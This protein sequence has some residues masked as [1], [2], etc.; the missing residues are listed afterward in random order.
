MIHKF[1]QRAFSTLLLL[2]WIVGLV[3]PA[4]VNAATLPQSQTPGG[5]TTPEGFYVSEPFPTADT[6]G[7]PPA[8]APEVK[9]G[10]VEHNSALP[11]PKSGA[12]TESQAK[13]RWRRRSP[14]PS[15][16]RHRS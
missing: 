13:F 2:G 1:W 6:K 10:A 8:P 7:L 11:M 16:C 9:A 12:T 4:S 3:Q 14:V 5:Y 15:I